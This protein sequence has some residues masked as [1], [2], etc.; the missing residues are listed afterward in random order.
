MKVLAATSR[1]ARPDPNMCEFAMPPTQTIEREP[2]RR[3]DEREGD[4]HSVVLEL[5]SRPEEDSSEGKQSQ[6]DVNSELV[7]E[8]PHE[9][10]HRRSNDKVG[11][12]VAV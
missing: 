7:T 4:E 1:V 10:S 6:T 9:D 3:D 5:G 11:D 12:E 8:L 2:T